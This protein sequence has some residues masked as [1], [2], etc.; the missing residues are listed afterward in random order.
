MN[1]P[2]PHLTCVWGDAHDWDSLHANIDVPDTPVS[3]VAVEL[4][5][6]VTNVLDAFIAELRVHRQH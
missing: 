4:L 1:D 5:H 3:L 2:N 6:D